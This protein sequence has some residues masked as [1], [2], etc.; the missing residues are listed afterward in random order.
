[1]RG[2]S[3]IK[4]EAA[5]LGPW[6]QCSQ[7]TLLPPLSYAR[8]GTH[9]QTQ[10]PPSACVSPKHISSPLAP[11]AEQD[12][13]PSPLELFTTS[14]PFA[15]LS[16]GPG[17]AAR[18][19]ST[20]AL[21]EA[22]GGQWPEGYQEQQDLWVAHSSSCSAVS[23]CPG[24]K[25]TTSKGRDICTQSLWPSAYLFRFMSASLW[26]FL[27]SPT[28]NITLTW[29]MLFFNIQNMQE[30]DENA[31]IDDCM[32]CVCIATAPTPH[33]IA[34]LWQ[35]GCTHPKTSGSSTFCCAGGTTI[36]IDGTRE[37]QKKKHKH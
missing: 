35:A 32:C 13:V 5:V 16:L 1:M 4:K 36:S 19:P 31:N 11:A 2:Q 30:V 21:R 34:F 3:W 24:P 27:L 20:V 10:I 6:E 28:G 33:T 12:T 29:L 18:T 9:Y 26:D 23:S 7:H 8:T 15:L 37:R 14:S 25:R 22:A 17:G